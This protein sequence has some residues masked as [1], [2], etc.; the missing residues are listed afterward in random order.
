M[1]LWRSSVKT[2]NGCVTLK[3]KCLFFFSLS[4]HCRLQ[5][6]EGCTYETVPIKGFAHKQMA[7]YLKLLSFSVLILFLF[8]T[9]IQ[10]KKVSPQCTVG[11]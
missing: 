6:Q 4:S 8:F 2:T 11:Q 3:H 10:I 9:L 5:A 7:S 1:L